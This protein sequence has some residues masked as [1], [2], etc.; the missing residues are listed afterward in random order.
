MPRQAGIERKVAN[1][2]GLEKYLAASKPDEI[3]VAV[4]SPISLSENEYMQGLR[5]QLPHVPWMH[6][7][8]KTFRTLAKLAETGAGREPPAAGEPPAQRKAMLTKWRQFAST[9][10]EPAALNEAQSKEILAAYGIA[11]PAEAVVQNGDEVAAAANRIGFPVVLK[12]VSADVAHKS[13]AGLVLLNVSNEAQALAGAQTLAERCNKIGAKL[14]GILVAQQVKDGVEMVAG[15]H[16]DPE[17]GPV[18]MAGLG[19]IWLEL[20]KDVAFCPPWLDETI[21]RTRAAQLRGGYRGSKPA[22][23]DALARAMVGLGQLA[24]EFGDMLEAVDVNPL[25]VQENGK[26]ALALDGLIVLRPTSAVSQ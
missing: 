3:P 5:E 1:F 11:M 9:L 8:A 22:D 15:V 6:D 4:F 13:D 26:G 21:Q 14:E 20:F 17:M 10:N 7:I 2:P 25:L 18:V 23:V 12:A 16:R 19:G 24:R